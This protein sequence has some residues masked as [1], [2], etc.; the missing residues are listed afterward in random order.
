M[1]YLIR[2]RWLIIG[3][4]YAL[5]TLLVLSPVLLLYEVFQLAGL[6]SKGWFGVWWKAVWSIISQ[7]PDL[8]HK[9]AAVQATR[10]ISD[11]AM[12]RG[13]PLPLTAAFR[14]GRIERWA[15]RIFGRFARGYWK[16]MRGCI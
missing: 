1:Y 14:G 3:K 13:G 5:R 10:K 9:R 7:L 12:L 16:V 11:R 6:I 15:I 2:N 8:L 4:S